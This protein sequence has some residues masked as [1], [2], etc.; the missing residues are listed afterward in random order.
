ML[1]QVHDRWYFAA[2]GPE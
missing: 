2:R 1:H